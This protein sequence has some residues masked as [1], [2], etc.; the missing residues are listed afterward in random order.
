[1]VVSSMECMDT[2]SFNIFV[3]RLRP[4]LRQQAARCL[5]NAPRGCD[6]PDDVLQDALLRLW[7]VRERLS[8]YESADAV[9]MV[10]TRR[11][12]I[13][14]MRRSGAHISEVI[15]PDT[16]AISDSDAP[17][18]AVEL[19]VAE[20]LASQLLAR[21]PERQAMIVKMRHSDGLEISEIATVTGMTEGNV[22]TLLS[23][24]RSRLRQL[25]LKH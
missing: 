4:A 17:D 6:S 14:A 13:D 16:E 12:A 11:T 8:G 3:T 24:G 15:G 9:A 20:S 22:R 2:K 25:Y 10:V 23:R 1:M 19:S 18:A 21:L 7:T 5:A